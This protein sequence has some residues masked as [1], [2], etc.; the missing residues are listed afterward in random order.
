MHGLPVIVLSAAFLGQAAELPP[1]VK[2]HARTVTY[3]YQS[4]DPG[5]GPKL[6]RELLRK[7]NVE[8]PWFVKNQYALM[9]NAAILGDIAAGKPKMVREYEAAFADAPVAGRRIIIR[10][11]MTCGDRETLKQVDAWLA[12]AAYAESRTELQA[13]KKQL[14]DPGR[15]HV[16]DRRHQ[17]RIRRAATPHSCRTRRLRLRIHRR[18]V[19]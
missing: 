4:P 1:F 16:R 15:K 13:L 6:L 19:P 3:Y 8:H 10:S 18:H 7:E 11:L 17:G 5:L 12:E 2:E 9:L 14:E